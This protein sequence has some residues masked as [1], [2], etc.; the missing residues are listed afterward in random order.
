MKS[1]C[2]VLLLGLSMPGCSRFTR[3][4]QAN[5]YYYKQLKQANFAR[6][7]QRQRANKKQPKIPSP[8]TPPSLEQNVQPPENQ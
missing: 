2:L 7:K 1:L 4:G 3:S 6:E 8:N 5:R